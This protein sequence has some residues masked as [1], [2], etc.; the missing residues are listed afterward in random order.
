MMLLLRTALDIILLTH[1][2]ITRGWTSPASHRLAGW[3]VGH[4]LLREI[5]PPSLEI[6]HAWRNESTRD[7][8][9]STMKRWIAVLGCIIIL[10]AQSNGQDVIAQNDLDNGGA[11]VTSSFVQGFLNNLFNASLTLPFLAFS[12]WS[13][14]S[15]FFASTIAT[16]S[17]TIA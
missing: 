3:I 5:I 7:S 14:S 10:Y 13:S 16:F 12:S 17:F 1:T 15:F 6:K 2:S 9:E 4:P 11:V 8:Q